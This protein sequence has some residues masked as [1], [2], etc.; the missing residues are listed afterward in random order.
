MKQL[1]LYFTLFSFGF[2]NLQAQIETSK[3]DLSKYPS[4]SFDLANRNPDLNENFSYNFYRIIDS[5]EVLID[6]LSVAPIMDTIDYDK[7]NKCVLIL[8][9][10]INHIDRVEQVNTF[11]N[12]LNSSLSNFVNPGDKIQIASFNIKQDN[13]PVLKTMH[14][15]F[16][17]DIQVLRNAIKNHDVSKN[18]KT[19]A[20][21]E[22]PGAIMEGIDLLLDVPEDY[23]KSILLLSEERS[24]EINSGISF[25]NVI[26]IAKDKQVVI[27]TIKYNRNNYTQHSHEE[28]SK[29]TYGEHYIL[30]KSSGL[31]KKSN[32]KKQLQAEKLI[33]SI[34][35]NVVKRSKGTIVNVT[36][37]LDSV[38]KDGTKKRIRLKEINST[39]SDE[40]VY[41]SPGNWYYGYFEKQP[42]LTIFIS[43]LLLVII[44]MILKKFIAKQRADKLK[45]LEEVENQKKI[46]LNQ[47]TE[48][49]NQKTEIESIK[50][51]EQQRITDLNTAKNRKIK[52]N[53]E[54]QL[55]KEMNAFGNLP[56]LKFKDT[57]SSDSFE[58]NKP[59]M[60]FGR[61]KKSN[62][63]HISNLNM[64]RT[65]FSIN[66]KESN[67]VILDNNSTNGMI[68]NGYK[69]K[70]SILKHGDIIEIADATFTFYL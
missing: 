51:I 47:Q 38:Y 3:V 43:L 5:N 17:D 10:S 56:I 30:S 49:L 39:Y 9:E 53:K 19:K 44:I 58:I 37:F 7:K 16:T 60:S 62:D 8:I 12:A 42:L 13:T 41:N 69:L 2:F 33:N 6:S 4:I 64:S 65:H 26:N 18:R 1:V 32:I 21:S 40:F 20:V 27:N 48:I 54:D 66:F 25:V 63:I 50:K 57:N 46:H 70:S 14:S 15:G 36:L 29:Q 67:Y 55:I 22:I 11:V 59:S 61:D 31:L 68:I 24:N 35:K 45:L 52:K 34:L 28:L 23:N